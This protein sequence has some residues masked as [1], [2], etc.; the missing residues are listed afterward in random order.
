[1]NKFEKLIEYVINEENGKASDLFHEIVLEKKSS[2]YKKLV[3]EEDVKLELAP[4]PVTSEED[5]IN[6]TTV[7]NNISGARNVQSLRLVD[8]DNSG[9]LSNKEVSDDEMD[10]RVDGTSD[11]VHNVEHADGEDDPYNKDAEE[12]TGDPYA[13]SNKEGKPQKGS[14]VY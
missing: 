4:E 8:V 3:N 5:G 1:M 12:M 14:G 6:T 2:I 11:T 9:D 10:K 7:Q 13:D